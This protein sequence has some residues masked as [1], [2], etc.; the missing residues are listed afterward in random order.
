M[1]GWRFSRTAQDTDSQKRDLLALGLGGRGAFAAGVLLA[2]TLLIGRII[3][4]GESRPDHAFLFSNFFD[5]FLLLGLILA[6]LG[7]YFRL[8]H[9][10]RS[11]AFFLLPMIA[12]VW[13]LGGVL[14]L[15]DQ[16]PF[17]TA[18]TLNLVHIASVMIG[19]ACLAA[20]CAGGFVYLLA[21][22]Q[23]RSKGQRFRLPSLASIEKFNQHALYIGFPL[24]T[25]AM[26]TGAIV[27]YRVHDPEPRHKPAED[28][29]GSS[30]READLRRAT[31]YSTGSRAFRGR[32]AAWLSIIEF[33][34]S[35]KRFF[36]GPVMSQPA[37]TSLA[38]SPRLIVVGL[39]HRTRSLVKFARRWRF[40]LSNCSR[41]T[42]NSGGS[43]LLPSWSSFPRVIAWRCM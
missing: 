20:A 23:L 25:L 5:S 17:D 15:L 6:A 14:G 34:V 39:N 41:R 3:Q 4:Q 22:R 37:T 40:P 36:C 26:V 7:I 28:C 24:L 12:I 11:L 32:R 1:L 31:A 9:H 19:S 16:K 18:S 38:A 10:L 27:L 30:S 13:L 21:D 29:P 35:V 33:C 42:S 8:T 43:L 2:L